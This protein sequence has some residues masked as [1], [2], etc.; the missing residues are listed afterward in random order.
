M[1][2]RFGMFV[3]RCRWPIIGSWLVAMTVAAYFAPQVTSVLRGGGYSIPN[4]QAEKAYTALTHAYGYRT[5][6]FTAVF[7]PHRDIPV[8]RAIQA[9]ALFRKRAAEKGPEAFLPGA[10]TISQDRRIVFVR[11]YTR[12]RQDLG[13]PLTAVVRQLVP[14]PKGVSGY[15]T[16]SSAV[17]FDMEQ[18][19][20]GDL[21]HMEFI[22]FPIALLILFVIFGT[23]VGALV[24][25]SMGP[26][27]VTSALAV[28]FLLGH[29]IDMS[30]FVLNTTTMLGLGVA[31]DYSLFM[32]QRF[33]EEL[34]YGNRVDEA[35]VAT[36]STS[37][38]AILV[39]A[40]T[41]AIGFLGMTL[42]R[43]SM[44]TSLGVGGSVVVGI[45]LLCA[46]TFLP[47]ILGVLGPR[48]NAI[49]VVPRSLVV[50][51]F[52]HR[53][54]GWVM[55]RPWTV[56]LVVLVVVLIVS[57]PARGLRVGVPGPDIL[58]STSPSRIGDD[59]LN[60]DIGL[61]NQSPVLVV[62]RSPSDFQLPAIRLGLLQLAGHICSRPIVAGVAA[63]P[64]VNSK[65]D[66]VPCRIALARVG[67][68]ANADVPVR[69]IALV[70]I[71]LRADPSS[72]AA[73][74]FVSYL[75]RLSRP[76]GVQLFVG[77]QTAG[78][79]DF[80]SFIYGRFPLA[81]LFVVLAIFITL[82]VSFRSLL[83]PLKAVAMNGLSVLAAYGAAVWAF[84]DGA[85]S[86]VLGFTKSGSLDSIVPVFIFCV[87]FGLSTDYEVFL[88]AR[89]R[90]E[91]KKTG[92]NTKSVARGLERT[93]RMITSAALIMVVI[94]AAFSFA[95]LVV[96]KEIGFSLAVGVL[97]DA[98]LIRA[99][100]VPAAMRVLGDWNWWPARYGLPQVLAERDM[101]S[102]RS[103][104]ISTVPDA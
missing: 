96:I 89:V 83:L 72:A 22:T 30:I 46:L 94:F 7:T 93:G 103:G 69:K 77:G 9:A 104:Y 44:L 102:G 79:L 33:R 64:V 53:L 62:L 100:L 61:A 87:L 63:V 18:V 37:G 85:L 8:S 97:V 11:V 15:V 81:I 90:E 68:M 6:A 86:S 75:R 1:A 78:Q 60:H 17:F 99:L 36:V 74:D 52:W 50:D 73:E 29:R 84:Q 51:R 41:V 57:L 59:L 42:F 76:P 10:P 80:D 20:D 5:L 14:S 40:F 16:G 38:V 82:A 28:V 47:A 35:L 45:S 27:T 55:A 58:P 95:N 31:I 24:P 65:A 12:P 56:I 39:S 34:R 25:V 66:I 48:V 13:I 4:S 19:S 70:S 92:D 88:L 43:V 67:K 101:D 32:V 98:T 54:S 49:A 71:Y 23:V 2:A 26:L 3:Y 21:R 91:F